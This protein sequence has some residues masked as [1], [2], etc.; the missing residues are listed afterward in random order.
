MLPVVES[1]F[2]PVAN[3]VDYLIAPAAITAAQAAEAERVAQQVVEAMDFE[4]LRV[5]LFLDTSGASSSTK[6][7]PAPTTADTTPSKR[8]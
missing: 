7:H 1:V 2:D 8:T 5:E 3:L 4:G 6:S